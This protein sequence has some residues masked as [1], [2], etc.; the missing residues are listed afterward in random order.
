MSKA[1]TDDE[2]IRF[3]AKPGHG[4]TDQ[5]LADRFEVGREA[6][7]KR[8]K[9]LQDEYGDDFFIETERGRYR[10]DS[11]TFISNIKVSWEE[12]LI[13]Y[14]ATR[15]LSR[16]TRLPD[17]P[18]QN[19]LSKL[20][21]ALY[22]P[23]TERLVK[24]AAQ[25]PGHP[26]TKKREAILTELL[27]GW[28][29]QYKVHIRYQGLSSDKP[30]NHTICPYLIEPSPWSD[31]IYV[32]A[33]TNVWDGLV[34]FQLERIEKASLS[35]E[36]FTVDPEFAEET[37]FKYTWGI[38]S[39]DKNPEIVR[40]RFNAPEAIRRLKESV[41]HP[42]Q[43]I[44]NPDEHGYVIWA[45]PIAEWR[46]MLPWVRGWGAGVEVL[47]PE[48]LRKEL[49]RETRRLMKIYGLT[50]RFQQNDS[51]LPFTDPTRLLW[52][53]TNRHHGRDSGQEYDTHP[54]ICHLIDVAQM[55]CA[56]WDH[57]LPQA[58]CRYFSQVLNLPEAETRRWLAF[59]A[60]LHDLGKSCP[61][62]QVSCQKEYPQV[63]QQLKAAG[64][65][66]EQADWA[67]HGIVSAWSLKELFQQE[68]G[69]DRETAHILAVAIGGHHGTIITSGNL[70][71]LG[72]RQRGAGSW[73]TAR[74]T[75]FR[76]LAHTLELKDLRQLQ[77]PS[78]PTALNTFTMTLAGFISF[79][80]W[81]GSMN[82]YFRFTG[83]EV[84]LTTYAQLAYNQAQDALQKLGWL[85]W[86]PPQTNLSFE[87][88]FP[89]PPRPLQQAIAILADNGQVIPPALVIVEAPT[90]EGKTEA[91]WYLADHWLAEYQQR[92]VYVA[93]PT[94]ATSNQMLGRVKTFLEKRYPEQ[95]TNLL[96]LHGDAI[97]S[98]EMEQ[99]KLAAIG[100]NSDETVVAHAWFL[101][102]KRSLLAPFAV[103]T[104]DQSLLAVLQTKHFFVR[105]FGLSHKTVIFD[106]VHAYD[107]YMNT[108]LRRLL[109]WLRQMGAS[110][111]LLSAT[112]PAQ[113]RQALIE[114]YTG[115]PF[116]QPVEY[117]AITWATAQTFEVFAQRTSKVFSGVIPLETSQARTINLAWINP[118]AL[119]ETIRAAVEAG[120]CVAVLCNTVNQAQAIYR[121]LEAEKLVPDDDLILFHARFPFYLRQKIEKAVLEKFG[122][123]DETQ[124]NR[125]PS[126]AI[127]VA[128]QVIEQS[129]DLD[130]DLMISYLA[131]VDLLLQ[132]AGRLH[133]HRRDSRPVGLETP[134]LLLMQPELENDLPELGVDKLIYAPYILLRSQGCSVL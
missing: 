134:W 39:S 63:V 78:D 96:L 128:T 55:V 4:H 90:G 132:R 68:L 41:W 34:P 57:H 16:N 120:G 23:M 27:R 60:G 103:G 111:I 42:E 12:A 100:E 7:F 84:I 30:T 81:L 31:S 6:I 18:V 26:E 3:Y 8:R 133:R 1:M 129:L 13:L 17:R 89:F 59:L 53:K 37:L 73:D 125:R 116:Q 114:A 69:L 101:P 76:A 126:K 70:K 118:E 20:A 38:W 29:E 110:V 24:A 97:F 91:A 105:L 47:E 67:A 130:F 45:A 122:K 121:L 104:V 75:L 99:M 77:P 79:A 106:E 33:K 71:D 95:Q 56:L 119:L 44:S 5:E 66:F 83:P 52:A 21:T 93:M 117:P 25:V 108:L 14:L 51:L 54:L 102:K 86:S 9:K 10:I 61:V 131:P 40:L 82:E 127:V 88:L 15:R 109:A 32:I 2:L 123:P 62:F 58:T 98:P 112:L 115:Q 50:P 107:T 85:D 36:P 87:Q 49:E 72:P 28:S 94:Q 65:S 22:K 43:T 124:P 35:T 80:D 19:A 11:R 92:G 74:L 46:E 48:K 113:T 64:F